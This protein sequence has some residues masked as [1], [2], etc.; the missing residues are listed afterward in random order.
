MSILRPLGAEDLLKINAV[1]IDAWT[2]TVCIL[3]VFLSAFSLYDLTLFALQ[4]SS[5]FYLQYLSTWPDYSCVATGPHGGRINAYG[6]LL[7]FTSEQTIPLETKM[8]I[9]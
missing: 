6:R 7:L 2:E 9:L 1:N 5:S 8:Y 4:Y 3:L